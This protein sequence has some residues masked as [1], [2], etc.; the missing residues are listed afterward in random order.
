M[1]R[2]LRP[3]GTLYLTTVNRHRI[4]PNNEFNVPLYNWMPRL[5][6]ECYVYRHL[7]YDPRLANY[8]PR[9]AVHWWSYADLCEIGRMAGF[10]EFYCVFD[11]VDENDPG[12]QKSFLRRF[13]PPRQASL[14]VVNPCSCYFVKS[15]KLPLPMPPY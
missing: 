11:L 1:Y 4:G 3:G 9:P 14:V 7:H 6:K 5:V 8:S 12:V 10:A 2:T 13:R 15:P